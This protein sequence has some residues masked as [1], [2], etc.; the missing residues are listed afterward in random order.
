MPLENSAWDLSLTVQRPKGPKI[1]KA[2]LVQLLH[3]IYRPMVKQNEQACVNIT[4]FARQA[5]GI[6]R[7]CVSNPRA[8]VG[9]MDASQ[10]PLASAHLRFLRIGGRVAGMEIYGRLQQNCQT[11]LVSTFIITYLEMLRKSK[12]CPRETKRSS[13]ELLGLTQALEIPRDVQPLGDSD[14]QN[15]FARLTK[16]APPSPLGPRR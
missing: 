11:S 8:T 5:A 12:G 7:A 13:Q 14:R 6:V 2:R 1:V 16:S 9:A 4:T 10:S 3:A 15:R